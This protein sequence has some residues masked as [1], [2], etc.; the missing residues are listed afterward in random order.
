M[1]QTCD[2]CSTIIWGLIQTWY[3]CT[4]ETHYKIYQSDTALWRY[5]STEIVKHPILHG[6]GCFKGT[7]IVQNSDPHAG[8]YQLYFNILFCSRKAPFEYCCV[9]MCYYYLSQSEVGKAIFT[10][11]PYKYIDRT[12]ILRLGLIK[13]FFAS[14][15]YIVEFTFIP[16]PLGIVRMQ[17]H[18]RICQAM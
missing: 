9:K 14:P 16:N 12:G 8:S 5:F 11:G 6:L 17:L 4:G 3:T 13:S 1:K 10:N 7:L 2:K 15:F 18:K